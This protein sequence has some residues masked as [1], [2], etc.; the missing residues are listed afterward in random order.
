M[1][2]LVSI[3]IPVH[4][5]V[6]YLKACLAS[7]ENTKSKV[8][9]EII[10]I[11]DE[12]SQQSSEEIDSI[13]GIRLLRNFKNLGFLRS[14]NRAALSAHGTHLAFLNSDTEVT[15]YWL[16]E[17]LDVHNRFED[18][19]IVGSKLLY[20]TGTLQEFGGIIWNNATGQ[21]FGKHDKDPYRSQYTYTKE[22]DYVSGA[23]LL[24]E[25]KL[26]IDVGL[27]DYLYSPAYYEDTD[28]AFK[29]RATGKKVLVEPRSIVV[30]H[31]GI[32]CGTSV[33]SGVKKHQEDNRLKF[34]QKW[35]ECL[36]SDQFAPGTHL[37]E[38]RDRSAGRKRILVIDHYVP[39]FDRDAGSRCIF[40]YLKLLTDLGYLVTF[41]PHN[42]HNPS[43]YTQELGKLGIEVLY[44]GHY[45]KNIEQ[46]LEEKL[47]QFDRIFISRPNI[48]EVY[49]P[50]VKKYSEAKFLFFGHDIHHLRL[51]R[52]N[53]L[54]EEKLPQKI[55]DKTKLQEQS[56]WNTADVLLY[57][58]DEEV[59]YI[60][61][62]Y[63]N[64]QI[65]EVPIFFYETT[66]VPSPQPFPKR[67]G[68]LFVA[69]FNHPPNRDG[70]NW[71][72]REIYPKL[73]ESIPDVQIHIIGSAM[74]AEVESYGNNNVKVSSNVS[75][76]QLQEAYQSARIAIAPLRFG[77]GVKGKV[78][79]SMYHQL[80]IVTTRFGAQGIP[81]LEKCAGIADEATT[82][83]KLCIDYYTDEQKW[84]EAHAKSHSVLFKKFSYQ[85]AKSKLELALA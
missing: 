65:I 3:I 26:F 11:D 13:S 7:I 59:H 44:G 77:A 68:I 29:V 63:P 20:P 36:K 54:G 17:L 28:L 70:I 67:K 35:E 61:K 34:Y 12:S 84:S 47:D 57:P 14:C 78:L 53:Q 51:E 56:V 30:H 50:L 74:P 46:W 48:A 40:Q 41:L 16:D 76:E 80:P 52:E 72:F 18:V 55:I 82:F 69:N 66:K 58:S 10:V 73:I 22:V 9:Y 1:S 27:F 85:N 24:I 42:F 21:N 2:P 81:H 75:D 45:A 33:D 71:F 23:S 32:S 19:G 62:E 25:K 4:N 79:E 5:Q 60:R 39:I 49:L 6:E 83:L 15:D 43:P 64:K 8:E 38:A 37:F 31:E